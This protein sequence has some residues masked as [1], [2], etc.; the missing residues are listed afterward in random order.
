MI[1]GR[2]ALEPGGGGRGIF[3]SS[4]ISPWRSGSARDADFCAVSE[5]A[6]HLFET[7]EGADVADWRVRVPLLWCLMLLNVRAQW[8]LFW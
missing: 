5:C 2:G 4:V 8:I 1:S 7:V 3:F 6:C